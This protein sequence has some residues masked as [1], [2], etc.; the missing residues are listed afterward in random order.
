MIWSHLKKF[1]LTENMRAKEDPQFS[2]FLLN[3]GDRKLQKETYG[4]ITLPR[5]LKTRL[6]LAEHPLEEIIAKLWP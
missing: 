4:S 3:L 5:F 1:Q 6:K 2:E